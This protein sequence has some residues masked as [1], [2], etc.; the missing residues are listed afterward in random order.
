MIVSDYHRADCEWSLVRK[1]DIVPCGLERNAGGVCSY[2][3]PE[4]EVGLDGPGRSVDRRN[5]LPPWRHDHNRDAG[6]GVDIR[7]DLDLVGKGRGH[8]VAAR[9]ASNRPSVAN[10]GFFV[11][12][13]D[14]DWEAARPGSGSQVDDDDKT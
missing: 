14:E 8:T 13:R 10:L 12:S 2:N 7:F 1:R 11:L 9:I 3:Q 5:R 6:A 4:S